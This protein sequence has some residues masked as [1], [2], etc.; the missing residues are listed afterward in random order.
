MDISGKGRSRAM[1][2]TTW[3][4]VIVYFLKHFRNLPT[5][6]VFV[7]RESKRVLVTEVIGSG[8]HWRYLKVQASNEK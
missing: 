4:L 8:T 3:N 2:S 6:H 7:I 1:G 5:S